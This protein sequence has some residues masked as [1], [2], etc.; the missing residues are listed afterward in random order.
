MSQVPVNYLLH[1][2]T[3]SWSICAIHFWI[4]GNSAAERHINTCQCT[5]VYYKEYVHW[6]HYVHTYVHTCACDRCTPGTTTSNIDTHESRDIQP[7][8]THPY[9][10]LFPPHIPMHTSKH[11]LAC[12]QYRMHATCTCCVCRWIQQRGGVLWWH[13]HWLEAP[14]HAACWRQQHDSGQGT[15]VLCANKRAAMH[16]Y[17]K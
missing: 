11:T 1:T 14:S 7:I 13:W 4:I 16:S 9:P 8:P 2:L 5:Y 10:P 6:G 3:V 12:T 15:R 17:T